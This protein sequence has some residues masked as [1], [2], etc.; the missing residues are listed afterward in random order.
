MSVKSFDQQFAQNVAFGLGQYPKKLSSQYFYDANGDKLFQQ[1]MEL[2]EYYLTR[3]E[4]EILQHNKKEILSTMSSGFN[5]VEL[6]VGDGKK[7]GLLL[8]YLYKNGVNFTY[9]PNDI[10]ANA[11]R[12]LKLSVQEKFPGMRVEP[13]QGNYFDL[14]KSPA[15]KRDKPTLMLYLGANIG[16]FNQD[17]TSK[18]LTSMREA[19]ASGDKILIGFDLKKDPGVIL[20]AYNDSS[21]VTKK[22]NLNLLE[23]INRELDANFD[24]GAFS[25][26]P[27]YDPES[28]Y[29]KSY[30][31]SRSAQKVWIGA[32]EKEI[33]FEL[34][35]TILTEISR[36]YNLAQIHSLASENNF[37]PERI[38]TDDKNYFADVLWKIR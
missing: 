31:V 19:L 9:Y 29:C 33:R 23:R 12:G 1:I 14:L 17:L 7:S 18:L 21:G 34:S 20:A 22:F 28:G 25:H 3:T 8:E 26:W 27:V 16:N 15:W 2:P 5:L 4:F 11:L 6:G 10:S 13:I 24:L 36:K 38:F 37:V 32:L 30:L 35:E